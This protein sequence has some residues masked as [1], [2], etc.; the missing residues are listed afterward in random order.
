[1]PRVLVVDDDPMVCVAI[2]VCLQSQ[3]F[4]VTIA[5]GGE[6]GM[7]ALE[8]SDF[9]V[10]LIDVFM[11]QMRGFQSIRTF[12]ERRPEVPIIA[13]SGYGFANTDRAPDLLRLTIE[14]GAA[15]CL[16]KP[17]TPNALLTGVNECLTKPIQ[18]ARL[19]KR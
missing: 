13:M 18:P 14:L 11:P 8:A 17:F 7:Q 2:E 16:R 1:M 3:G 6:A 12:H 5:D 10:M 9:D 4:D 15:C 19:S